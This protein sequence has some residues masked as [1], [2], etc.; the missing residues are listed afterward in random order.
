MSVERVEIPADPCVF[1]E[2]MAADIGDEGATR[3]ELCA[4]WK[5][6][7]RAVTKYLH[8]A[9]A[10]GV[11]KNGYRMTPDI[12]GR[13]QRTPVYSFVKQPTKQKAKK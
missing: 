9:Q 13:P 8:A 6:S 10:A 7:E 5:C 3:K 11:L 4:L 12:T 1:A 2:W